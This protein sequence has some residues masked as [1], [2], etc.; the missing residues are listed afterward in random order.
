MD[1]R[2]GFLVPWCEAL[3]RRFDFNGTEYE[4]TDRDAQTRRLR[5][6]LPSRR[7]CA[8]QESFKT[9]FQQVREALALLSAVARVDHAAWKF[10]LSSYCGVDLGKEGSEIFEEEIPARFLL[11][12]DL[13]ERQ[14]SENADSVDSDLVAF[15]GVRQ[16]DNQ[17]HEYLEALEKI[18]AVRGGKEK[19]LDIQIPVRVLFRARNLFSAIVDRPVGELAMAA[20]AERAIKSEWETY[21][22]GLELQSGTL[23]SIRCT[24]VLEPMVADF[25]NRP[26][27]PDMVGIVTTLIAENVWFSRATISLSKLLGVPFEADLL[28]QLVASV[29]DS[30]RRSSDDQ[31]TIV[32]FMAEF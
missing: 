13:E 6:T 23:G 20:R 17:A 7:F 2:W 9:K 4:D 27:R 15:C 29:F 30:T 18:A 26:I 8:D 11:I 5:V 1:Q 31:E 3:N 16:R 25:S 10:L 24:F 28:G 32:K 19:V 21:G 22:Q 14:A 12:L